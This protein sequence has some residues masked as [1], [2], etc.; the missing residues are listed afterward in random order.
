[1]PILALASPRP[2]SCSASLAIALSVNSAQICSG[3]SG[4][5]VRTRSGADQPVPGE[6]LLCAAPG[7]ADELARL[8]EGA[9][10]G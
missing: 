4:A 3:V 10:G 8:W 5:R 9:A 2:V 7:L 6:G 1:M